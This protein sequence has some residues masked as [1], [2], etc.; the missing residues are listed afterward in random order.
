MVYCS[1]ISQKINQV[2]KIQIELSFIRI[3]IFKKN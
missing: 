2:V 3:N 1:K